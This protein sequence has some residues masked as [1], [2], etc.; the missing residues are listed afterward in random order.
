MR[1]R[2]ILEPADIRRIPVGFGLLL[3]RSAPPI[4]MT[5]SPWTARKDARWLSQE[6]ARFEQDVRTAKQATQ[7]R[8][9][10]HA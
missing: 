3:L 7:V 4:M 8:G 2:P 6:R 10:Q 1:Y 9:G 5:L